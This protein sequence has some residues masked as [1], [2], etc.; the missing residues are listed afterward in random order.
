VLLTTDNPA[1]RPTVQVIST[2]PR[3]DTVL[4]D[5]VC[6]DVDGAL[7]VAEQFRKLFIAWNRSRPRGRA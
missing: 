1:D 7:S 4:S 3:G 2:L 6:D 5:T